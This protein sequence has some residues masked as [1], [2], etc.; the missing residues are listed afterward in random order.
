[1]G[2]VYNIKELGLAEKEVERLSKL[3][4]NEIDF[5]IGLRRLT[6]DTGVHVASFDFSDAIIVNENKTDVLVGAIDENVVFK[7]LC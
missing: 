7:E 3:P 6:M 5:I 2:K 4:Q 1:M